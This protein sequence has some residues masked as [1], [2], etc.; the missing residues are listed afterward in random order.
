MGTK[1]LDFQ[2]FCNKNKTTTEGAFGNNPWITKTANEEIGNNGPA[3]K[4]CR[5]PKQQQQQQQRLWISHTWPPTLPPNHPLWVRKMK[6]DSSARRAK[7][8]RRKNLKKCWKNTQVT[9]NLCKKIV[10]VLEGKLK[11]EELCGGV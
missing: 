10:K 11:G 5:S 4:S 7:R 1:H 8:N 6:N 2:V 3:K 9:Q